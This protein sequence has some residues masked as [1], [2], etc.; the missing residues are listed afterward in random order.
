VSGRHA[1]PRLPLRTRAL[2]WWAGVGQPAWQRWARRIDVA[3]LLGT[4]AFLAGCGLLVAVGLS[5]AGDRPAPTP[6]SAVTGPAYR[7]YQPGL[8]WDPAGYQFKYGD[9]AAATALHPYIDAIRSQLTAVTGV[10]VGVAPTT[11]TGALASDRAIFVVMSYRPCDGAGNF[12]GAGNGAAGESCGGPSV[13][14]STLTGGVAYLDSEYWHTDGSPSGYGG[15]PASLRNLVT[16]EVGHALG[17]GHPNASGVNSTAGDCVQGDDGGEKPVMCSGSGTV[18]GY[19]DD[20]A[21]EFVQQFDVQGLRAMAAAGGA[22]VPRQGQVVGKGGRCLDVAMPGN[23]DVTNGAKVELWGC[24]GSAAQSWLLAPDGTWRALGR[25]LDNANWG[26]SDG[27][28]ITLW[29]CNGAT[30]QGWWPVQLGQ[31][32]DLNVRNP[33]AGKCLDDQ[34]GN[35]SNGTPVWLWHCIAGAGQFWYLP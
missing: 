27:N 8:A 33:A 16:H 9:Q 10:P 28:T 30:A 23:V 6:T 26:T 1:A 24:N 2:S 3:A 4:P 14:G 17:L 7:L 11:G 34:Y 32:P 29:S 18:G 12:V 20:R 25:C 19:L 22:T 31:Q 13:D 15:S 21:G 35:I 5:G